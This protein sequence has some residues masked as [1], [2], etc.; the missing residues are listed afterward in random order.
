MLTAQGMNRLDT[1]ELWEY[2]LSQVELSVSQANFN[3]WFRDSSIV[4]IED[5]IVY[6][7]VPSQFFRDWYLKKFHTLL[8][9]IVRSVSY[10]YRNIEYMIL[11]D[12]RRNP[13]VE[14]RP[15]APTPELPL[16]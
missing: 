4:K 12:D 13:N 14:K 16:D 11:K 5:G 6:I 1:R 15:T 9:K 2:M 3:T 7:G 10:E 8:L